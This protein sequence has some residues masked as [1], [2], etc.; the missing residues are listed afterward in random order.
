MKNFNE[1]ASETVLKYGMLKEN[2][3]VLIALSG[4]PDSVFLFHFLASIREKLSLS[5]FAAHVNHNL[6]GEESN[7]DE[8]F[9][10][11]LCEKNGVTLFVLSADVKAYA[12]KTGKSIEE[13]AREIR[14]EF[15]NK[16]AKE[17][18][19]DK[20]ALGHNADDSVETSLFN[21]IRGTGLKGLRG[22]LP[23]REN[24]IRPL[25]EI[26]KKDI[27]EYLTQ[28]KISYKI[29]KTNLET[30][31]TRNKI[32]HK[33]IP[34]IKEI[35]ESFIETAERNSLILTQDNDFLEDFAKKSK[36]DDVFK[37]S[38]MH[39]AIF[40]R[41]ISEKIEKECGFV[42]DY[43]ML[44]RV[45]ALVKK[46]KTSAKEQLKNGYIIKAEY[47]K[48]VIKRE[49]A[50]KR[51]KTVLIEGKNGEYFVK[52]QAGIINIYNSIINISISCDKIEGDL[53][54]RSRE[55][56]DVFLKNGIKKSL[57]KLLIDK[58]IPQEERNGLA[59][60]SDSKKIFFVEKI[61]S[62]DHLNKA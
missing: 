9:C 3:K 39:P 11:E 24:L 36:T 34:L 44:S 49:E 50:A 33:I 30:D 19:I 43:N 6:R 62:S 22:I 31:Y 10:R 20:I 21:M 41:V 57:K 13:A 14:Y 37:L 56:G 25:I 32:R 46:N 38:Q 4:G 54:L 60:I 26:K 1:K 42:P 58:K 28:N 51:E 8:A 48:L 55:V 15:F 35:N 61:G 40:S 5:L 17:N 18:E 45:S 52:K 29:D 53:Y 2:D 59:V 12:E 23:V 7:S 47:G 16:T 27:E